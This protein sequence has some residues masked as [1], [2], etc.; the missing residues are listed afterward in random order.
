MQPN[1]RIGG[2]PV[3]TGLVIAVDQHHARRCLGHQRVDERHTHG[4]RADDQ[5][6]GLDAVHTG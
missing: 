2:G 1:E 5:V 3:A 4:A 6:V